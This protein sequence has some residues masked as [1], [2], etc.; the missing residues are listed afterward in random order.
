M[1]YVATVN[2]PG[3][4]P[5]NDD[6]PVFDTC[7]EAWEYL[8]T[9]RERDLDDPM[10]DED[11]GPDACLEEIQGFIDEPITGVVYGAT[12]GYSLDYADGC[13]WDLGLAYCVTEVEP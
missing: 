10:N 4:L 3:Y 7:A 12:P 1:S 8:H 5:T 13:P 9:E 6:P 11:D 2:V